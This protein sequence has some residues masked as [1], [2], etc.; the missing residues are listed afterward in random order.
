MKVP[1]YDFSTICKKSYVIWCVGVVIL[2]I[3]I[4]SFFALLEVKKP[5]FDVDYST[6][7]YDS[8]NQLLGA[9]I[10]EDEQWRFPLS[11]NLPVKFVQSLVNFEDRYF[12]YHKG[13]NGWSFIRAFYSNFRKGQVVSG[14]STLTMQ[15]VR[16]KRKKPR[17]YLEKLIEVFHAHLLEIKYDKIT[18]LEMYAAHAPFGGNVVGLEAASWRFFG[19]GMEELS[20]AESAMLAVLPNSP[21]LIHPSRNR[22]LLL[23]KRNRLLVRLYERGIID[24]ITLQL[25]LEETLPGQP[26]PI[27]QITP[28]LMP[29]V[30]GKVY[31]TI[32]GDLQREIQAIVHRHYLKNR[33][34]QIYNAAVLVLDNKNAQ[35]LAYIGNTQ[36]TE[37]N[38]GYMVD[39]ISSERST[40]SLLKPLLY[41]A[42]IDAGEILPQTLIMDVP[43]HMDGFSPNNFSKS[44]D[45]AVPADQALSRSL[46]VPAVNMLHQHGLVKFHAFLRDLGLKGIKRS[47]GA[48]GLSLI[49]GGAESSLWDICSVYSSMARSLF[50]F[51]QRKGIRRYNKEDYRQ[52]VFIRNLSESS[53][54]DYIGRSENSVFRAS[55]LWCTF[56]ALL[57]LNRPAEEASWNLFDSSRKIAW[58]TGTSFGYRDAWAIGITP[59]FTIGVWVGN[60]S[61][62]GRPG[63]TGIDVAAPL[64]FEV[65]NKMPET[66]WFVKPVSEMT[67]IQTCLH[68]GMRMSQYCGFSKVMDLPKASLL[69]SSCSFCRIIHLDSTKTYRVND[70]CVPTHT[71]ITQSWFVLPPIAEWYY[72]SK[73]PIYKRLPPYMEACTIKPDRGYNMEVIYP[74]NNSELI[75]PLELDGNRGKVVFEL[76][77]REAN[78]CVFWHLDDEFVATTQFVH[79]LALEPKPGKRELVIV[80][81]LGEERRISFTIM[82]KK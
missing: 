5:Y 24:T 21:A 16:L 23:E 7:M 60:A 30:K 68:S 18:L 76:I 4:I 77:H 20:W 51:D 13:T 65:F 35:V 57:D 56:Q 71:M 63:L 12:F 25:S 2:T 49:L 10:A 15:L 40:G 54:L 31:S 22:N 48:Y 69:S 6:V 59:E 19:R 58:K 28:H 8:R 41:A 14:G 43:L 29:K 78:R 66:T 75:I 70:Q 53:H 39:I 38:K 74:R 61:G 62:E 26:A 9:V 3:S 27:P 34:N 32:D 50:Y 79:K 1:A 72:L 45:G 33:H 67:E 55:S 73:N 64:L 36:G 82:E 47:A 46:N 44:F 11:T 42:M 80:D 37:Q 17:T 81:E 52:P